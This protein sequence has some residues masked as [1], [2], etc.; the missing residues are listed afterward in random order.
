MG[1]T[2]ARQRERAEHVSTRCKYR[3]S[4]DK[5]AWSVIA[6]PSSVQHVEHA[7]PHDRHGKFSGKFVRDFRWARIVSDWQHPGCQF[8]FDVVT[9]EELCVCV[10]AH[11]HFLWWFLREIVKEN[12]SDR[13]F[14]QSRL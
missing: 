9:C 4:A 5:C 12:Q 10:I 11:L 6:V 1:D 3:A 14:A 7:G 2:E 13:C 8:G